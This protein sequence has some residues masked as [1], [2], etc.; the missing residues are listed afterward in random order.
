[1]KNMKKIIISLGV[2][3]AVSAIVAGA[4][5]AF[6]SDT[7]TS[8]NNVFTAGSV[9]LKVDH[10]NQ[11]YNGVD[12]ETC[13]LTLYS[14]DGNTRVVDSSDN[15]VLAEDVPFDAPAVSDPH[16]E[17][18]THPTS[19]W[20]WASEETEEGDDGST[21][22]DVSY[23]FEREFQWN[24]DVSDIDFELDV[25]ADNTYEV[26]LNGDS[27][28]SGEGYESIDEESFAANLNNGINTLQIVVINEYNEDHPGSN[29]P[30]D[31]PGGLLYY[32]DIDREGCEEG[33]DEFRE[34]CRLWSEKNMDGSEHFF[35]FGDIKPGDWGTNGLSFHVSDNDSWLCLFAHNGEDEENSYLQP[36]QEAGDESDDE[37]ELSSQL[38]AFVWMD[39]NKDG[40]YNDNEEVLADPASFHD[41]FTDLSVHDSTTDNGALS[42][43]STEYVGIAWCAGDLSVEDGELNCDGSGMTNVAQSDSFSADLTAFTE[44]W[45]NNSEFECSADMLGDTEEGTQD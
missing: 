22:E 21:G 43:T 15:A 32:L 17:W 7:E 3:L 2:V 29:N 39:E 45:R 18:A 10:Y 33:V 12:C 27:V 16:S 34:N 4:T 24:G 42:A 13:S 30:E 44:Q 20:V 36:E 25:G 8:E 23:T 11:T 14:A 31:N 35:N 38:E 28:G 5:M 40:D 37:G 6:Y 41:V 26:Y 1:M 9:D 19:T